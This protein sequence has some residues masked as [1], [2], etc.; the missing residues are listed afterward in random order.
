MYPYSTGV[1]IRG[2]K[3]GFTD[4]KQS[5]FCFKSLQSNFFLGKKSNEKKSTG[6]KVNR[7]NT[8]SGKVNRKK[9]TAT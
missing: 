9:L 4:R 5:N 7:N 6:I 1:E 3:P 2:L 8:P